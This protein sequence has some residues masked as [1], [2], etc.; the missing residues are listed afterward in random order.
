MTHIVNVS[1]LLNG[2]KII[3]VVVI[4]N[5]R[6]ALGLAQAL[7]DGGIQV[8]EIT[9]RNSYGMQ[10]IADVKTAFPEILTLAGTVNTAQS[11]LDVMAAGADGIISPGIT[12]TLLRTAV[13]NKIPYLPGV[14][15]ASEVLTAMEHGLSEC[16]L[17]PATV[18]G[19]VSALKAFSGPL[20]NMKFCPTGGVGEDNYQDFLALANVMC[21]GGSWIAPSRLIAQA[22]WQGISELCKATLA[23]LDA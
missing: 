2:Q 9:L 23:S 15:T 17:F 19:G 1:D 22:D 18:V 12:D 10:A 8:I 21:V 11:M 20:S 14:A 6:Q 5:K 13:E 16:K 7:L 4:E 3:P